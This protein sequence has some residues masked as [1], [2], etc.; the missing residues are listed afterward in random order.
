MRLVGQAPSSSGWF[1]GKGAGEVSTV[2]EARAEQSSG[3]FS[4]KGA[5]GKGAGVQA[6]SVPQHRAAETKVD[7]TAPQHS[8]AHSACWFSGKN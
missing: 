1:S 2:P 8:G 5:G 6:A 3:W 7:V 4:G